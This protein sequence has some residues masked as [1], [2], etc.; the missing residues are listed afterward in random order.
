MTRAAGLAAL[1]VGLLLGGC[2]AEDPVIAGPCGLCSVN[3]I[4]SPEAGTCTC[5][6]GYEGDGRSCIAIDPCGTDNGGCDEHATCAA[7]G[8]GGASCTCK[9][10]FEGDGRTCTPTLGS[11]DPE[12]NGCDPLATC[13]YDASGTAVCACP[14]GYTGDGVT[15]TDIDECANNTFVCDPDATCINEPG[16]YRCRC[17]AGFA[18]DGKTCDDVPECATNNGGCGTATCEELPGSFH[19]GCAN[20]FTFQGGACIAANPSI[21]VDATFG[22]SLAIPGTAPRC[23]NVTES[24]SWN[25][26]DWKIDRVGNTYSGSLLAPSGQNPP[27]F[28]GF[29][30]LTLNGT[31]GARALDASLKFVFPNSCLGTLVYDL[32]TSSTVLRE[33]RVST[34]PL[35]VLGEAQTWYLDESVNL[36]QVTPSQTFTGSVSISYAR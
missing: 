27:N 32:D 12:E 9:E 34:V 2:E 11:C 31:T 4:C 8:D 21:Y 19:C 18:G 36:D 1:V 24:W 20:G 13:T 7:G 15:C 3:A 5:K 26:T 22:V 28:D 10:G 25:V 30:E 33:P 29:I 35:T 17:K 6:A 23:R 14:A 16:T